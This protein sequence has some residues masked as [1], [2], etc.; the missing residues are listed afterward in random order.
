MA[1][2]VVDL[3]ELQRQPPTMGE[4]RTLARLGQLS[5][6]E[7]NAL[8]RGDYSQMPLQAMIAIVYILLRRRDPTLSEYD[9]DGLSWD[10]VEFVA[11]DAEAALVDP[12]TLAPLRTGATR[13][14][15]RSVRTTA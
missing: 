12:P 9:I 5:V 14:S 3:G 2:Y 8:Q 13:S 10:D 7:A 15:G 11:P 6:A 4:T 1:R